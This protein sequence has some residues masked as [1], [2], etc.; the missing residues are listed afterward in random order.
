MTETAGRPLRVAVLDNPLS[1]RHR[2][3]RRAV[4][5]RLAALAGSARLEVRCAAEVRA[6]LRE[7]ASRAADLVVV[8]GGDGTLQAVLTALYDAE[9]PRQTPL[10]AVLAGGTTNMSA[11]DVG[12]PGRADRALARVLEWARAPRR[13][14]EVVSR[15]LLRVQ[16]EGQAPQLGLFFSAAGLAEATGRVNALR[17]GQRLRLLRGVLG[18]A[19]GVAATGGGLLLGRP[20]VTPARIA[21]S[22]NGDEAIE[23]D[24]LALMVTTLQRM[25]LGMTPFWSD[26]P[27]AL[28]LSAVAA[29]PRHLPRVLPALLRGRPHPRLCEACGYLSRNASRVC[30]AFAG[31]YTVDGEFFSADGGPLRLSTGP[32]ARFLRP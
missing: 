7:A 21:L 20:A 30:L 23:G 16:A 13:P 25:A 28:R 3:G 24:Y 4:G 19:L 27:G 15:P 29:K 2:L 1:G 26:Q 12:V 5:R 10:L 22:L 17:E 11:G 8:N 32:T 9:P 6:A 14:G 18:I 31:P